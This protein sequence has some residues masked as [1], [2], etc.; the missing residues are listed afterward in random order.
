MKSVKQTWETFDLFRDSLHSEHPCEQ[1]GWFWRQLQLSKFE[2]R[3]KD[4]KF[5]ISIPLIPF[6]IK[7]VL[8]PE[9]KGGVLKIGW[10]SRIMKLYVIFEKSEGSRRIR[11]QIKVN[12]N[13]WGIFKVSTSGIFSG[14]K[15]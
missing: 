5:G 14:G 3:I 2:G 4:H 15:K 10:F 7:L 8:R 9:K 6:H 1:P 12:G 11:P 13:L